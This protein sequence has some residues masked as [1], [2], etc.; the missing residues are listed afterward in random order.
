MFLLRWLRPN[1]VS[2]KVKTAQT[3]IFSKY[4]IKALAAL[5]L[6]FLMSPIFANEPKIGPSQALVYIFMD[7]NYGA[8]VSRYN[9]KVAGVEM[10]QMHGYKYLALSLPP[11]QHLIES[12]RDG[13]GGTSI[14]LK[15][16]SGEKHYIFI[17]PI[18]FPRPKP[19][20][21]KVDA[22]RGIEG[23][24]KSVELPLTETALALLA[25]KGIRPAKTPEMSLVSVMA[26]LQQPSAVLTPQKTQAI[27]ARNQQAEIDL[28]RAEVEEA[29][30]KQAETERLRVESEESKRKLAAAEENLKRLTQQ[31][32]TQVVSTL[33]APV[34]TPPDEATLGNRRALV[35]GNDNYQSVPKLAN[36]NEDARTIASTLSAIG[37]QVTLRLDV[38]EREMKSALR[39]FSSQVQGGDEVLFFF[40]G[41]GVQLG[42]SNYLLPIDIGSDSEA[43]VRDEAIQ[44]QRILDD[45][46]DRKA[47]FTLALLDACRDNPFKSLGRSIGGRGLAPTTAATGQMVIFSAGSGQQAMDKLSQVDTHKNGLFTRIFVQ[48]IQKSG[49]SIDRVMK[50]VR[51]QVAQLARSV[52]HEQ[53][54]AIY[55]QVLGDFYFKR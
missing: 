53:V 47:K 25:G 33:P 3:M 44:L 38:N 26:G 18:G 2:W 19:T 16:D 7:T 42:A 11:G 21:T 32:N 14:N 43:Q 31:Q 54:P 1:C 24:D 37:Y 28:L 30:K 51:H 35:I 8:V 40:A 4:S 39:T 22:K 13:V 12:D 23:I 29:R 46:S 34:N 15:V 20:L 27:E 17:D 50:N 6:T 36:A 52:G 49:L 45:F 48:E 41:H 55:D 9:L 10:P 5:L